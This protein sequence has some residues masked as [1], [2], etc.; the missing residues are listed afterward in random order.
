MNLGDIQ[1]WREAITVLALASF[2][3]IVCWA[4]SK[5]N[6]QTFDDIAHSIFDDQSEGR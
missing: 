5:K 2:L 1:F 3:G 4:Y 6:K